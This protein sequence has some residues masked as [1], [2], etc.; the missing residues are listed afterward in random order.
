M[1]LKNQ[2]AYDEDFEVNDYLAIERTIMANDRT[3]LS[4]LR[5]SLY[6]SIAGLTISS[7]VHLQNEWLAPTIFWIIG[8]LTLIIGLVKYFSIKAKIEESKKHVR[9][10]KHNGK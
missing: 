1:I 10:L 4:F 5:T 2:I 7:I 6:F 9:Q 8:L 3:L